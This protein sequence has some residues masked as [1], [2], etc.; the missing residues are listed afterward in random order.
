[1]LKFWGVILF[2]DEFADTYNIYNHNVLFN[3]LPVLAV[4]LDILSLSTK[5]DQVVLV[6][7]TRQV[8]QVA[9]VGYLLD[10]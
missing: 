2:L 9:G 4:P 3:S 8:K 7:C 10:I 6:D 1:M 5:L